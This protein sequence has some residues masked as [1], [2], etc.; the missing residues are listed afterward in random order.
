MTP[1]ISI[2]AAAWASPRLI[3]KAPSAAQRRGLRRVGGSECCEQ[4]AAMSLEAGGAV[5]GRW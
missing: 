1:S 5:G 4:V 2:A 3:S